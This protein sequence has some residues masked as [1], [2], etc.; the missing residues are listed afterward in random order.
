MR[1]DTWIPDRL[2]ALAVRDDIL[3]VIPAERGTRESRGPCAL[4]VSFRLQ[5]WRV[6]LLFSNF[7]EL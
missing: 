2:A 4:A 6:K 3:G 7:I 5:Q 1:R